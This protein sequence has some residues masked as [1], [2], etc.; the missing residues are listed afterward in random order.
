[1]IV[2]TSNCAAIKGF[3]VMQVKYVYQDRTILYYYEKEK[4]NSHIKIYLFDGN[5]RSFKLLLTFVHVA[6]AKKKAAICKSK[7]NALR[8]W[9]MFTCLSD[10]KPRKPSR[11]LVQQTAS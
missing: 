5:L 10:Q 3:D 11:R 9:L 2:N 8:V 6:R 7:E 4:K 1:M